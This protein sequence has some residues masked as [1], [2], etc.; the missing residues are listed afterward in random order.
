MTLYDVN[1]ETAS[2]QKG[3]RREMITI[4]LYPTM[5]PKKQSETVMLGGVYLTIGHRVSKS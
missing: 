3:I 1:Q 4:I 5:M 2:L